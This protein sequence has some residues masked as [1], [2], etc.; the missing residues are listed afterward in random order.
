MDTRTDV[1]LYFFLTLVAAE[2]K[3]RRRNSF[4]ACGERFYVVAASKF[5]WFYVELRSTLEESAGPCAPAQ[6]ISLI[7][8]RGLWQIW[9]NI[10]EN[11]PYVKVPCDQIGRKTRCVPV[12]V[13]PRVF[14]ELSGVVFRFSGV[15]LMVLIV[16]RDR[17]AFYGRSCVVRT[18]VAK[19]KKRERILLSKTQH[20]PGTRNV[21]K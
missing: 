21:D 2:K 11:N 4:S 1:L 13:P 5:T 16:L 17:W 20:V 3:K 7:A 8:V 9:R 10:A 19:C 15:V 12:G 18:A 14:R 6:R